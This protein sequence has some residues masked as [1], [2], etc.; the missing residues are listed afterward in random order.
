ML[1]QLFRKIS[2]MLSVN[3]YYK[4]TDEELEKEAQ[5]WNIGMYGIP[6]ATKTLID[7]RIIIDALI[8]RDKANDSRLAIFISIIALL[9]SIIALL[10]R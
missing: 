6:T 9:I 7:R 4:M 2:Q 1:K 10:K 5:K 8:K 3:K